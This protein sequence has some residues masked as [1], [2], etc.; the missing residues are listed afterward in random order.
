MIENAEQDL[1]LLD[2]VALAE[3]WRNQDLREQIFHRLIDPRA[4][5]AQNAAQKGG[6]CLVDLLAKVEVDPATMQVK[7]PGMTFL[8]APGLD[9]D[10]G[11]NALNGLLY[12][13][14]DR[15]VEPITNAPRLFIAENC[16]QV[17]WAM[18]NWTGLDGQSG[19]CKEWVDLLRYAATFG[20]RH[21]EPG[22]K[23]KTSGMGSY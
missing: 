10:E 1:R 4:G 2:P 19:A 6:V 23:V 12:W 8:P 13:D 7:V 18:E 17:I 16:R 9:I 22:G 15:D 11:V 5:K 21:I 3:F 14:K 20:L